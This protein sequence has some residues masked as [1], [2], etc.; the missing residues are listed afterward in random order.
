MPKANKKPKSS[1]HF[2]NSKRN[3]PNAPNKRHSK[4]WQ[5]NIYVV[6]LIQFVTEEFDKMWDETPR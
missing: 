4:R 5:L 1:S 6:T 2:I 3:A